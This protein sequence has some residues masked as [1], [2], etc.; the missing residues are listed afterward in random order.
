MTNQPSI[1]LPNYTI[2]E[3]AGSGAMGTVYKAE[4]TAPSRTVALKV[5]GERRT[6]PAGLVGFRREAALIAHLEH[7]HIVP[8]YDFGEQDGV[9]YLVLRYLDG[10]TLADRLA[11]GRLDLATAVSWLRSVAEA[12]DFAHKQG[13]IHKDIKPSNIL[14]DKTG[15][16]YLSDF[17]IAGVVSD[18][19]TG[20]A[21]GSAAYMSPEQGRGDRVDSRSDVYALGVVLYEML[22]GQKPY[23]AE[24]A[25]G[26]IVRHMH[27]PVPSARA[28]DPSIAP[29]ADE[30]IAWAMAKDP[31]DRPQTAGEFAQLLGQVLLRPDQPLRSPRPATTPQKS[32]I[33]PV[34]WIGLG[35]VG[36]ICLAA[37][38][39]VGGNRLAAAL[40]PAPTA[41]ATALE[42]PTSASSVQLL[43]DDFSDPGSGFSVGQDSDGGVEYAENALRLT[44]LQQGFEWY[45]FSR[46]VKAR[47]VVVEADA[48]GETGATLTE[49]GLICRWVDRGNYVAAAISDDGTY[50]IWSRRDQDLVRLVEWTA[51]PSLA[52]GNASHHLRLTCAADQI[53]FEVD[54]TLLGATTDASPAVGDI[55]LLAGLRGAPPLV[56]TFDNV[57]VTTPAP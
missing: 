13:V 26:V 43:A 11:R 5:L 12:L 27:D 6:D 14:L 25:L 7:P 28:I 18:A 23:S 32:R 4:Q 51:A 10:G 16:A 1:H 53:K 22:T 31:A 8:V 56:V 55:A 36:V 46:R 39:L 54:G 35:A 44:V 57:R 21:T 50:S 17:G 41:V 30:L 9:A 37:G 29:A 42:R 33:S 15:N 45:S 20:A 24:T 2:L 3:Q 49:I 34:L 48:R 52:G 19:R 47:D 40:F 38:A